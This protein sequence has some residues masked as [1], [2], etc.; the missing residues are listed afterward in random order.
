MSLAGKSNWVYEDLLYFYEETFEGTHFF[1][2]KKKKK[3]KAR[4]DTRKFLYVFTSDS[5]WGSS[6]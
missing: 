4:V 5:N 2:S 3:A 1:S 6:A